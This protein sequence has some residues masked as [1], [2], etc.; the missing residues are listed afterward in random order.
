MMKKPTVKAQ[1]RIG[2]ACILLLFCGGAA[3]AEYFYLKDQVISSV[4]KET[5]IYIGIADAT[6]TYVKD[7]ARPVLTKILPEGLFIPEAM[8]TSFVG[9]EIMSRFQKR[10]PEFQYKRAATKPRNSINQADE[11]EMDMIK[12]FSEHP[13]SNQWAGMI[14]KN[15]RF[16]YARMMAIRAETGCLSCHGIPDNAPKALRDIYGSK[17]G[18]GYNAGDIVAAD[19]IYIPVD[20]AFSRIREK[21]WW[22]FIIAGISLISLFGLFYL[23]FNRTVIA[24]LKGVLSDL[25]GI[26]EKETQTQEDKP[27]EPTDE[28]EQ[29]KKAFKNAAIDL[30]HAHDR[31]KASESKYRRLFEASQD[32]IFICNVQAEMLEINEAGI[33]LFGF[34]DRS[35]ALSI[36]S[37]HSLFNDAGEWVLIFKD[38]QEKG[39]VKDCET[40][41][42]DSSGNMMQVLITANLWVDEN[43]RQC[44][45]EGTIRDITEKR[46]IEKQLSQTEK[47]ASIGQ[48]AAGVAHEINNPLGVIMCYSNLIEK[49][50]K[51]DTQIFQDLKIIKKHTVQCKSVVESL[52][53]FARISEPKKEKTDIHESIEEILSMLKRGI[54]KEKITLIRE[55]AGDIPFVI[56]DIQKMKQV[57][58][59]LLMNAIQAIEQEGEI[60]VR[61]IFKRKEN[62]V[63]I[64]V[65]DTGCGISESYINKIFD[66]F[67]TTKAAGKGTGLGLAIIYGIVKQ[68]GGEIAVKS[69]QGNGSIFTILLPAK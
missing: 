40:Q 1:F 17:G 48:L 46:R 33:K 3:M 52:L 69:S 53:N 12:W 59:N 42:K 45:F 36:K 35:E 64:E 66:P 37:F 49:N 10:F 60:T 41:M 24:D 26:S 5:E 65:E 50:T 61:T 7:K 23:L 14:E 6:R 29:L 38:I 67:F 32:T 55:F 28:I 58:M 31:L 63:A 43:G 39:F 56:M 47:L 13:E 44:G 9:R 8:S 22:V 30:K 51:P 21:A 34:R 16:Y 68:H 18:Y 25:R 19:S 57:F 54:L 4:Y 2:T 20:V 27:A 15:E 62:V 11:F